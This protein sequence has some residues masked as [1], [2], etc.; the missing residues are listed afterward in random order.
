MYT[1]LVGNIIRYIVLKKKGKKSNIAKHVRPFTTNGFIAQHRPGF[2][3]FQAAGWLLPLLFF[4][5]LLLFS[6]LPLA[7]IGTKK[8]KN[9]KEISCYFT[10]FLVQMV[11]LCNEPMK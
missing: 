9:E 8:N 3:A 4:L 7:M 1:N 6:P 11:F 2:F 5:L 10:F